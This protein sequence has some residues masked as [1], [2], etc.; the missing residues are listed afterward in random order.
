MS[1]Y[2]AYNNENIISRAVIAG[3]LNVLNNSISYNQVWANDDIEEVSVPWFYNQSGDE[4]FMQDFY[5]H[6]ASCDFP[7][8]ID[9]N[10]DVVPRGMVTYTGSTIDANRITSRFVK[11]RYV[12]EINGM[13]ESYVSFLYSIPLTIKFDCEVWLDNQITALKIEQAIRELFYKTVTFYVFYK[14]MRIGCTS[15]FSEESTIEKLIE[16]SLETNKRIKLTFTIEVETYQPVFDTTT[17]MNAN[18]TIKGFGYRIHPDGQRNDGQI[19]VTS[20]IPPELGLLVPKGQPLMIEWSYNKEGA[21]ISNVDA[22]WTYHN[23]DSWN[24]IEKGIPNHEYWFWN[25]PSTFT[26]YKQPDIIWEETDTIK[27]YKNPII[28]VI[29]DTSTKIIDAS[30][31]YISNEGYFMCDSAD[32]SINIVLEMRDS[33]NRISYTGDNDIY[34][35]ISDYKINLSNPIWVSPDVSII[36]PG[37]IDNKLIDIYIANSVNNSVFGY[38]KNIKIV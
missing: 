30:S 25:I 33:Q 19:T 17:E 15:G 8:L 26:E 3:M 24:L 18:N 10:F 4:R 6:Y 12:K 11:G 35:N 36:F 21:I 13:L 29:P 32:T 28:S 2:N 7:K 9:G 5:T 22:Y 16:Y 27:L 38:V 14:G 34:V 1:L 20:P 31:F 23:E 37:T